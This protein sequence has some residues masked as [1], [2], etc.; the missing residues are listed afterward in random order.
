[1]TGR[2]NVRIAPSP[3]PPDP[4]MPRPT[5]RLAALAAV[6]ALA[7]G[8][9]AV[10]ADG[11]VEVKPPRV[12]GLALDGSLAEPAWKD[13]PAVPADPLGDKAP[14]VKVLV[15][16]GSLWVGVEAAEDPGFPIGVRMMVAAD[17]APSAGD[18]AML[19]FSPLDLRGPR[20]VAR[21]PRGVGRGTYRIEGAADLSRL[22]RWSAEVRI[23]LADL[24]LASGDAPLALAVAVA[25]RAPNVLSSA[26]AGALFEGPAEWAR[27]A[28]PEGGWR[29]GEDPG[30]DAAALAKEDAADRARTEAWGGF[31]ADRFRLVSPESKRKVLMAE[32]DRALSAR[33]DL[34]SLVWTRGVVKAEVGDA[35]GAIRDF[36]AVLAA[37]PGFREAEWGRDQI[38]AR[39]WTEPP[40]TEP[41]DYDAAF[42]KIEKEGARLGARSEAASLAKAF[43]LYRKGDFARAVAAFAPILERYPVDEETTRRARFSKTYGDLWGEELGYRRADEA[44]GDLPRVRLVTS[45]GPVLLEL[46]EDQAPNTVKNFVWLAKAGFYDGT[47]FH[48]VVPFFVAQ[49]GD[50]R[51]AEGTEKAGSGGPGWAIKTEPSKRRPFRGVVA[52]ARS[53]APDT[54][55]S[56]FFVTTG[57]AAH[58]EGEV[59]VFGRVLEG[60]EAVDRT[61]VGDALEQVEVVRLRDGTEYRP[62]TVAGQPAPEPPKRPK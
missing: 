23:P 58:L 32:V 37:V 53:G 7:G 48:R 5:F 22:D 60:Q 41:S 29:A 13:A 49:G 15:S 43:L 8:G 38:L 42:S 35:L 33:P 34:V 20:Y 14:V 31:L 10:A 18:A 6:L 4:L 25:S 12:D 50:P 28:A 30:P 36:E 16:K 57:T 2:T 51:S 21:G 39:L 52:M 19:S 54:E 11:R 1:M 3:L 26:P 46:F 45:K 56:Q 24:G 61:V 40:G 62:K 55:G 47:R 17:G 27:V 59:S 9:A 44:K